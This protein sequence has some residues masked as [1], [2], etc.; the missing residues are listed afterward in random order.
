MTTDDTLVCGVQIQLDKS[1][2]QGHCWV[3]VAAD[4]IP[5]NIRQEIEAEIIDGGAVTHEGYR[6]SNGQLY[7]W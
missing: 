7:R 1:G 5:A 4:D 2:G 3:D 6:A